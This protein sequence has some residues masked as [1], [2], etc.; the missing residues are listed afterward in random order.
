MI[1]T[2]KKWKKKEKKERKRKKKEKTANACACFLVEPIAALLS[3]STFLA[4]NYIPRILC[5]KLTDRLRSFET[6]HRN[7]C[8]DAFVSPRQRMAAAP[9]HTHYT[10]REAMERT[11]TTNLV[12]YTAIQRMSCSIDSAVLPHRS[13]APVDDVCTIATS[14]K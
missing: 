6:L 11:A 13:P 2:H 12:G 5:L 3:V 4:P 10:A 9:T 14:A 7:A 1:L 8:I